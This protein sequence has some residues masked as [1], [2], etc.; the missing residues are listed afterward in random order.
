MFQIHYKKHYTPISPKC[1]MFFLKN[2]YYF[3]NI[4][5]IFL[6]ICYKKRSIT[7]HIVHSTM[8]ELENMYII[9][10]KIKKFVISNVT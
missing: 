9:S 5:V 6:H 1:Q 2:L 4:T 10:T 3:C 7:K 8:I